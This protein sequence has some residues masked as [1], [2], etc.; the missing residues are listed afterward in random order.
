MLTPI[1]NEQ[2]YDVA[3]GRIYELMQMDLREGSELYNELDVLSLFVKE[4]DAE[5]YPALPPHPIEAIKF[6]LEQMN[7]TE[8]DLSKILGA[9]SRKSE[10]LSGKRKLTL[11]MIRKLHD[12][13][14]ISADVLVQDY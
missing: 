12:K 13:L 5:H 6:R 10:I 14:S 11:A 9:R 4:Y 7:I 3:V 8:A 1:K 2:Q